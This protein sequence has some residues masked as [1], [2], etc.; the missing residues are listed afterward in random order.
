MITEIKKESIKCFI[1][2]MQNNN[3]IVNKKDKKYSNS[4]MQKEIQEYNYSKSKFLKNLAN[5]LEK[6]N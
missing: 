2:S 1:K 3:I 5:A 4:R 6:N